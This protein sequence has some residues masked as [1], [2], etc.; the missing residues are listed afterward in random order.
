MEHRVLAN[1]WKEDRISIVIFFNLAKWGEDGYF[2]PLPEIL[3]PEK[4]PIY[5]NFTEKEFMEN[6]FGKEIDTKSLIEKIRI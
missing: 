4:P 3:S 6:F 1:S 5:R 2:G